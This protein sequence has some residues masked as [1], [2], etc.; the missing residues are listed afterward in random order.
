MRKRIVF[1]LPHPVHTSFYKAVIIHVTKIVKLRALVLVS[2]KSVFKSC[3]SHSSMVQV[4]SGVLCT[5]S[6]TFLIC[7]T[8][9]L[10]LFIS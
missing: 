5:V 7:K 8:G 10:T 9:I 1:L 4:H 6:L 3:P 2:V